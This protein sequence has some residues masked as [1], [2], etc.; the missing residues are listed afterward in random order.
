MKSYLLR[1]LDVQPGEGTRVALMLTMGFSMGMFLATLTVA[2][3]SLFLENFIEEKDLPLAFLVSGAIGLIATIAY[4][5]LQNR[6]PFPILAGLSLLTISGLTAFLEF[7][8]NY[9]ADP[10]ELFF[11]GFTLIIPFSFI[12]Y[13][14]YW[15]TFGR[16]FNT[17]QAKRL[18]GVVDAGAMFASFI[19]YFSIPQILK[20]IDTV[21][22]YSISLVSIVL[23]LL[24]FFFLSTRFLSRIR[25][26][27]Q[28]KRFYKKLGFKEFFTNRYIIY[29]S[30]FVIV[31]MLAMN[32]VDYSF[33]NATTK[34]FSD[35]YLP[36]FI[37]YF[38]MTVVIFNFLVQTFATDRIVSQ[39]GMRVA[40]LINPILIG[41]FALSATA[42]GYIFGYDPA[43]D[44]FVVFFISI[45]MS[46]LFISS[47]KDA[48]DNQT[49]RLYLLPLES[50]VRIDVQTKIEG[51]VTALATFLAGS[52]II[53]INRVEIFD[54][55][56]ITIF[57]LPLVLAWYF[58]AIYMHKGY[59]HTLQHTLFKNKER[60]DKRIEKG[61]TITQ[62]LETGV[63]SRLEERVIYAL[64]LMEKLEPVLFENAVIR[65]ANSDS[66]KIRSFATEKI[67]T[68][69]IDQDL[70]KSEIKKLASNAYDES[71]HSDLLS[72]SPENLLKLSKSVKRN[73]RLLA[74]KLLSKLVNPKT[75]F[76]LMELLRDTNPLVRFEA[77][78]TARK[79]KR[80]E[81]WPILIELLGS[82]SFSHH[83]AAAL[84]EAGERVLAP[85]ESAFHKSGQDDMV[86]LR[87]VQI[88]GR[89][90]GN[91]ALKLL[92]LKADYPDKRIV[93]QILFSLRYINYQADGKEA[94]DVMN[95]LETELGKTIW[96]LAALHEVPAE[97]P[98]RYLR[99]ALQEEINENYDQIIMLLSILY[100]PQSVQLVHENISTRD[101]D[102]I[103]FALELLDLFVDSAL[104]PKLFPVLDDSPIEEKLRHLQ[105]YF[106]RERYNPIQVINY[107]LNRDFNLNNRWTKACAIHAAAFIPDFRISR[108]LIAQ[109]FNEDHLLQE[110]AAWVIY[111]KDRHAYQS[112][113]ERLPA[114]D[115]KY[116]DSS[117]E[118]NQLLN[119]LDDGF[120]LN[121][122]MIMVIKKLPLFESIHG[123]L[124]S[125]L[126][127]K[128]HPID[129]SPREKVSLTAE[130]FANP[131]FIV[132]FGE[133]QFTFDDGTNA[134]IKRGEILGELFQDEKIPKT[135]SL[136]AIERS[137]VFRINLMDFYFV[138]ANHHELVQGLIKNISNNN[139]KPD[140]EQ[141]RI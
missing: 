13:L 75:I 80:P 101:P 35:E 58:I 129:L 20:K 137:V 107:I 52:L 88:M 36:T 92:W 119:G 110:T 104:K 74:A 97:E 114:Y 42:V 141:V 41:L 6:I 61:Y 50:S 16:L 68:L 25:S 100:D 95:L 127:D 21:S 103:A 105:L 112:I 73:D 85:L 139:K 57:T 18:L 71:G 87:I 65:L 135:T 109:M 136:E 8:E 128:I 113:T 3:Q 106:P 133:V 15:G 131:V 24:L 47:L 32:F 78:N 55:F 63:N 22:L 4:N 43:K 82:P 56:T 98:F 132:A 111:N 64:K 33:L 54:Y 40:M 138:M 115:K 30:L 45:A 29:M 121:I 23:F 12:T 11:I 59:Q 77:L 90:G 53:L 72:I 39:Y 44:L 84:V 49:F 48:I 96:N 125:D 37:S 62:V 83:A 38:E 19:A 34:F 122:E 102:S 89:I 69:G 31:S 99:E 27:A 76:I 66:P 81:T 51:M 79:T 91:Y 94:R 28:E 70:F 60:L 14:I 2:S 93:K 7:G 67:Q 118:N 26:F 134:T 108:G 46:K 10:K 86:M 120:F 1:I 126:A 116:L 123:V 124:I 17:R 9:F 130:T 5:F 117:I 140:P